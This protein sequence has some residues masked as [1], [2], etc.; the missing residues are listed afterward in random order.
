MAWLC[1]VFQS[2][3]GFWWGF[4]V[5]PFFVRSFSFL[6]F[7]SLSGFWWGF[8]LPVREIGDVGNPGFQSLS[9]F[10]W[11][12]CPAG[13]YICLL[14]HLLFQSL[15]GFWWGFCG[16]GFCRSQRGFRGFNPFQ[17][18]GG[19]SAMVADEGYLFCDPVKFQ[20]L[21]GF[22][23]GF[24]RSVRSVSSQRFSGAPVSIPFRVLVGFLQSL[25][26][27]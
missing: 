5:P 6:Q 14:P 27:F 26:M 4:C 3:S 8:C 19:V 2:L 9:G 12:F 23:W 25:P 1:Y 13:S 11:G 16:R 10:W 20:S 21:S 18:F 17:G 22:W 15:S 7:Q 24:C